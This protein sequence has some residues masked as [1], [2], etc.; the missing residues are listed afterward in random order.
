MPGPVNVREATMAD[1][2]RVRALIEEYCRWIDLGA[3]YEEIEAELD[4]CRATTRR[5]PASS[6]WAPW[7]DKSRRWSRIVASR[8]ASRR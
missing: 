4:T 2:P 6:W 5:P 7:Q 1:M 8:R 3:A